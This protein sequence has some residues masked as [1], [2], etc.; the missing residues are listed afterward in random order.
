MDPDFDRVVAFHGHLC[1]DIAL[2]YRVT[3]AALRELGCERPKDEELV[4]EVETD[5]C[6]VDAVQSVTGCT[7]GKGN[8]VYRP[9]GKAAYSFFDRKTGRALRIYCHFWEKFDQGEGVE[10]AKT[11]NRAL[12]GEASAEERGR[13]Y[14]WMNQISNR[15]LKMP[16]EELFKI[17]PIHR[18]APPS[19]RIY[20]SAACETCGEWTM[21]SRL[22]TQGGKQVCPACLPAA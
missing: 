6:S 9:N 15:I 21:Q 13:F 16:E 11:M 3:R 2:G 12:S 7:F 1:M 10:F 5:S 14:E 22:S 17:T 18:D 19:A 20:E 4:A 8:L